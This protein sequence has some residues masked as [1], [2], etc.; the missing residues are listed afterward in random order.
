MFLKNHRMPVP[1]QLRGPAPRVLVVDDDPSAV[2]LISRS[3][4]IAGFETDQASDGFAA[5]AKLMSFQPDVMT[6]D[7]EMPGLRGEDVLRFVRGGSGRPAVRI[8]VI[9]SLGQT[10]LNNAR[11][12]GADDVLQKPVD[13]KILQQ[14]A[15]AL[16]GVEVSPDRDGKGDK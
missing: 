5:G 7:L 3:L 1:P 11:K 4:Q 10:E 16:A 9:S 8:L 15:A 6:L 2:K 13:Y 12:L 14:K